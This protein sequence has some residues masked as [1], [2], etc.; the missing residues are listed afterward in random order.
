M[1][2]ARGAWWWLY[3]HVPGFAPLSEAA[4]SFLSQRR[5]LLDARNA[6]AVG[7]H[8]RAGTL[9]SRRLAVPA[10]PRPHLCRRLR[11]AGAA[12]PRPRRRRRHPAA[13]RIPRRRAR[14]LGHR[15]LL[16][17]A[18]AVLARMQATP[19]SMTGAIAGIVAGPARH[20][21]HRAALRAH[22]AV[23][24]LPVIRLRRADVHELPVGHAAGG[25]RLPR[26]LPHRRL[27]HR[28]LALPVAVVP[29]PVPRR[30]SSSS[31]RATRRGS[32]SPRSTIT[33]GRSRCRRRSPGTRRS[34]R[35]GCSRRGRRAALVI[36]LIAVALIFLPRRPRMLAAALHHRLPDRHHAH[37]QLQL[38]QPADRAAVPVPLRRSGA[39]PR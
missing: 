17:L 30:R 14:R 37:R 12:D 15:R 28:R 26:D 27:A 2:P 24:P 10:R 6:P 38:V 23:R 35:I 39:A 7:P 9:R 34:S 18:D 33:S 22:R 25:S 5:G 4:Y 20:V 29:L 36:E 21:R 13:R 31:P 1:R 3:R 32:S 16:A 11:L 19:R 8:A